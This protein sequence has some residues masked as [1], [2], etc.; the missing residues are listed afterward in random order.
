MTVDATGPMQMLPRAIRDAAQ[1]KQIKSDKEGRI[2][3]SLLENK[4][5]TL[6]TPH[7][8]RKMTPEKLLSSLQQLL[9]SMQET[10]DTPKAMAEIKKTL[11]LVKELKPAFPKNHDSSLIE[12]LFEQAGGPTQNEKS[13]NIQHPIQWLD[14]F[15]Q[16][17]Q[18]IQV[19]SGG[20][21]S[22]E[23]QRDW[24]GLLSTLKQQVQQL[25]QALKN[26]ENDGMVEG[27]I[28]YSP[29]FQ[30]ENISTAASQAKKSVNMM[31]ENISTIFEQKISSAA[32]Q[33]AKQ[34]S[35]ASGH[36]IKQA[37]FHEKSG[38]QSLNIAGSVFQRISASSNDN[39]ARQA[40]SL[41]FQS[42]PMSQLEQFAL[43][44]PQRGTMGSEQTF[45]REFRQMLANSFFHNSNGKQKLTMKLH[46]RH[47]GTLN[48]QLTQKNGDMTA[49][50]T[51]ST[52]AAKHL[53]ES[54]LHQLRQAFFQQNLYIEKLQVVV[55]SSL[56]QA[57]PSYDGQRENAK[58][59][60][61]KHDKHHEEEDSTMDS[62]FSES[63][64]KAYS[65]EHGGDN[66]D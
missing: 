25:V 58:E 11:N 27:R 49:I 33:P 40:A 41:F 66:I 59:Q 19:P 39:N 54:Q 46:P 10:Q 43:H 6:K 16:Q 3:A 15:Q 35:T 56:E 64:E 26:H 30:G 21:H 44:A 8:D 61:D 53:V 51:T 12:A 65:L 20:D 60:Q 45:I 52:T 62:G 17:L 1:G 38:N 7:G 48:V 5:Q 36:S 50:L 22:L 34:M 31:P 37:L 2:F 57:N 32:N 63:L 23:Q 24:K 47:L 13:K 9:Q 42:G 28:K 55:P 29:S 18:N 14:W 4:W